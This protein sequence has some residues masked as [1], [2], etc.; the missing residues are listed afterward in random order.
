MKVAGRSPAYSPAA[1]GRVLV[2]L[3]RPQLPSL[4]YLIVLYSL[5]EEKITVETSV[6]FKV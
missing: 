1:P 6:D 3:Q 5:N 2:T 4:K